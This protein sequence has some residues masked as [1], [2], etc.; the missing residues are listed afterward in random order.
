MV[1]VQKRKVEGS[2]KCD[3]TG[4]QREWGHRGELGNP[5]V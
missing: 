2:C 5:A 1:K 4:L 3:R